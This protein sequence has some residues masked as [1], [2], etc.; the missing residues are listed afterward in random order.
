MGKWAWL[1]LAAAPLVAG[2]A[3]CGDFWQAPSG[4]TSFTLTNSGAITVS[5]G[6]TTGNTATNYR[7]AIE[8]VYRDG[9]AYLRGDRALGRFQRHHLR[10]FFVIAYFS[11]STAQT[12]TLTATTQSGTTAGDYTLR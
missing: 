8:F 1:L 6:A 4:S 7:Y 2:L 11:T 10:P 5:P 12:S 9:C 3:G